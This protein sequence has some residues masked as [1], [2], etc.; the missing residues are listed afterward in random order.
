MQWRLIYYN[1]IHITFWNI[2]TTN[3][4]SNFKKKK[5]NTIVITYN[6]WR[7][8]FFWNRIEKQNTWN[9]KD[10]KPVDKSWR[11]ASFWLKYQGSIGKYL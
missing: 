9:L 7:R 2:V 1:K 5:W 11:K 10:W 4:K 8:Y 3:L 6:D